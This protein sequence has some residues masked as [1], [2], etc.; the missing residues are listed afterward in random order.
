MNI[1]SRKISLFRKLWEFILTTYR[2]APVKLQFDSFCLLPRLSSVLA[3]EILVK[4]EFEMS[5]PKTILQGHLC[6][7]Q[8][9]LRTTIFFGDLD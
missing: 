5:H 7:N 2:K 8:E 4:T 9:R 1:F 6:D 3:L